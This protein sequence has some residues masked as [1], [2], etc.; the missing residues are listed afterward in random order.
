MISLNVTGN[1]FLT[2]KVN[3]AMY[4]FSNLQD[5]FNADELKWLNGFS[6]GLG[7]NLGILPMEFTA[8]YSPEI[9]ALYT[10]VK[11]GFLF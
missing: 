3:T 7:Y 9:N 5:V 2:G 1:L 6:L 11:I 10:H 8:M 4:N